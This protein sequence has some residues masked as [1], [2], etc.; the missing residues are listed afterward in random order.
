MHKHK[1]L[2]LSTEQT[3]FYSPINEMHTHVHFLTEVLII[4][5]EMVRYAHQ[6]ILKSLQDGQYNSKH[7]EVISDIID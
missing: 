1:S 7:K 3:P 4:G 5:Y 2:P 6:P